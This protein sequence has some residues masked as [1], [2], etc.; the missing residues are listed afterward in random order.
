M[1]VTDRPPGQKT[2][3]S[4]NETKDEGS[5]VVE[6]RMFLRPLLGPDGPMCPSRGVEL[7]EVCQGRRFRENGGFH[8]IRVPDP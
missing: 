8:C 5:S 4:Y 7:E 2:E 1:D 6:R 3:G